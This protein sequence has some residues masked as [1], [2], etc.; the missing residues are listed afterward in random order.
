MAPAFNCRPA[1]LPYAGAH[2]KDFL[3]TSIPVHFHTV[4]PARY[5]I[6]FLWQVPRR[7]G[8]EAEGGGLLIHPALFV[9]TTFHFY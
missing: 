5:T 4:P 1:G 3:A 8:R 2:C 7:G 6:Q 9:L